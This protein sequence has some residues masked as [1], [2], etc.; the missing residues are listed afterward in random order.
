M[1]DSSRR[2]KHCGLQTAGSANLATVS[3]NLQ[4][5][6]VLLILLVATSMAQ[7]SR[8][9]QQGDGAQLD[10]GQVAGGTYTNDSLGL[11]YQMPDGFFV[12]S[13]LAN[14]LPAGSSPL[15]IADQHTG[16]PWK[17]RLVLIADNARKYKSSLATE[18]YVSNFVAA[19]PPN[20]H[21]EIEHHTHL[22]EIA[23]GQFWRAD[24]RKVENG[25]EIYQAFI[26][27][28][29]K[30]FLVSWTF[31]STSQQELEQLADSIKTVLLRE[32]GSK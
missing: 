1:L 8:R 30:G 17:N 19:M 27:I 11:T 9:T 6:P 14:T 26:C 2:R 7:G 10:R 32:I 18:E 16:R 24:Y 20:L 5:L 25:L 29:L 21:V 13:D 4:Y 28:R 12:N 3:K 22:I 23:G 31:T 15:L